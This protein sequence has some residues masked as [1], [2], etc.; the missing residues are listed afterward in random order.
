RSPASRWGPRCPTTDW[1]AWG[2][3]NFDRRLQDVRGA[4]YT[5][6]ICFE[7]RGAMWGVWNAGLWEPPFGKTMGRRRKGVCLPELVIVSRSV[8]IVAVLIFP[9][10]TRT[11]QRG[12]VEAALRVLRAKV[13]HAR[14]LSTMIGPQIG[15]GMTW[16]Y[17]GCPAGPTAGFPWV[18]ITTA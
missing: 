10:F 4:S 18:S 8:A 1:R 3:S 16:T 7:P 13:E 2:S 14:T 17:N 12:K 5:A 15:P 6:K 11:E 9:N